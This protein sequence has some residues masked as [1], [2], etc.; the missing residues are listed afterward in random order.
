[1]IRSLGIEIV[2]PR[3]SLRIIC[4]EV[5][6]HLASIGRYGSSCTDRTHFAYAIEYECSLFLTSEGEVRTL[7]CP[8][9]GDRIR[10]I[11]ISLKEMRGALVRKDAK[12]Q[13]LR[14]VPM[15]CPQSAY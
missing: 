13:W 11:P 3:T 1:V 7:G 5:D 12:D 8:D 14:P 10:T 6:E 9:R 15:I 2:Y 4:L